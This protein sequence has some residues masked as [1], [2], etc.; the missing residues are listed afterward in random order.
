MSNNVSNSWKEKMIEQVRKLES[1]KANWTDNIR[2]SSSPNVQVKI[3][4]LR[5]TATVDEGSTINC[6]DFNFANNNNIQYRNTTEKATSAGSHGLQLMGETLANVVL[7]VKAPSNSDVRWDLGKVVLVKN[8]GT[9]MLVGEP[10]KVD[11]SI[12]TLPNKTLFTLDLNNHLVQLTT[13]PNE[14]GQSKVELLRSKKNTVLYPTESLQIDVSH[15][16][17]NSEV[18]VTP[19]LE[20]NTEWPKP[21]V[22]L[23]KGNTI[24]LVNDSGSPLIIK[25]GQILGDIRDMKEN[26]YSEP[27]AKV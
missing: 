22:T 19:R 21:K 13:S 11:N 8:L 23:V 9:N 26:N 27:K 7:E 14:T 5:T 16:F 20:F 1:R 2:K 3:G 15:I 4:N 6:L 18:A 25:K 10:G 24:R 17:N 12:V